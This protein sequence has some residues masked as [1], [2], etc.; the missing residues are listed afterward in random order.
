VRA[1][2]DGTAALERI[3][4][5]YENWIARQ[6]VAVPG[7][8][9]RLQST[10]N[11]HLDRCGD[12]TRAVDGD[13]CGPKPANPVTIDE[14]DVAASRAALRQQ[15]ERGGLRLAKLLDEALS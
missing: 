3:V 15:V 9:V 5:Q 14:A 10:A 6:R 12:G 2:G 8:E 11:E 7:L 1:F 13:P 4:T